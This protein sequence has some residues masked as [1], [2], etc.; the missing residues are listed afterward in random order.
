MEER[1]FLLKKQNRATP[2]IMT[3]Q[4]LT[5]CLREM[6]TQKQKK[7]IQKALTEDWRIKYMVFTLWK[8]RQTSFKLVAEIR[9]L[10]SSST[11]RK[12]S[13]NMENL[14]NKTFDSVFKHVR[15]IKDTLFWDCKTLH[16]TASNMLCRDVFRQTL[17]DEVQPAVSAVPRVLMK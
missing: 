11:E 4:P 13:Y 6:T 1:N 9:S 15:Q 10:G 12:L 8:P 16:Y 5:I 3:V 7:W 14:E 2:W 17:V